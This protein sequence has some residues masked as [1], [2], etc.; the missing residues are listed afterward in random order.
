MHSAPNHLRPVSD[1]EW[2]RETRQAVVTRRGICHRRDLARRFTA[3]SAMVV[4]VARLRYRQATKS[5]E[6]V[7]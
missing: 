5:R 7:V 2:A 1:M 3:E 4:L 6:I